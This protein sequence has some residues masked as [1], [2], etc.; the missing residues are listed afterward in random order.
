M[1]SGATSVH[2]PGEAT[3]LLPVITPGLEA[4]EIELGEEA[5][6]VAAGVAAYGEG[7]VATPDG[8][9][10]A[11]ADGVMPCVADGVV[12]TPVS[13]RPGLELATGLGD[14]AVTTG[15]GE[16]TAGDGEVTP[17]EGD[18]PEGQRPQVA[19]QY[20]PA[21]SPAVNMKLALHCP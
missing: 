12:V 13:A 15:E 1:A 11:V 19:A 8:L 10:T 5:D 18:V 9:G 17:D 6:A 21:G 2:R 16:V 20:P 3:G 7:E 14:E 4:E